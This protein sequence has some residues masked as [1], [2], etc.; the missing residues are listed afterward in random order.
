MIFKECLTLRASFKLWPQKCE[1][2]IGEKV[3]GGFA[4]KQVHV[5]LGGTSG[6]ETRNQTCAGE[7][8]PL[9]S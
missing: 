8:C 5:E 6:G 1:K 2:V 4:L 9:G 7:G 3:A